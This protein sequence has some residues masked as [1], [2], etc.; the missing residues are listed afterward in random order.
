MGLN[1]LRDEAEG[2]FK[3]VALEADVNIGCSV[4]DVLG[5]SNGVTEIGDDTEH[6]E[7]PERSAGAEGDAVTGGGDDIG[8]A[9]E[10][11]DEDASRAQSLPLAE[12]DLEWD[13]MNDRME[14]IRDSTRATELG[15]LLVTTATT[16]SKKLSEEC[17]VDYIFWTRIYFILRK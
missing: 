15:A 14:L 11:M 6:S 12:C 2:E 13:F 16:K 9:E 7:L 17:R 10:A 4:E 1:F 5:E 3:A 8:A